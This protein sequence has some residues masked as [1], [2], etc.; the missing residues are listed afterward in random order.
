MTPV[1]ARP[2]P[3]V[4][5]CVMRIARMAPAVGERRWP[6]S[7]FWRNVTHTSPPFAYVSEGALVIESEVAN[8]RVA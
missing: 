1:K 3:A 4:V 2:E 7:S 6:T 8:E 5:M